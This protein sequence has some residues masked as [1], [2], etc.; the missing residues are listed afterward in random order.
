[1]NTLQGTPTLLRLSLRLD[2]VRLPIWLLALTVCAAGSASSF[3][4]LYPADADRA[5]LLTAANGNPT[6]AAIYGP[7]HA[8][9][10]G[11]LTTWRLLTFYGVLTG[12]MSVLLVI[13]HTRADEEAGRLEL[14]RATVVGRSAR[15]A[16]TLTEALLAVAALAV[17]IGLTMPGPAGSAFALG[18]AV[19]GTGLAAAA[20]AALAAQLTESPR[21]A[22]G[23]A[24][25][26]LG[27]EFAV[28]AVA[29]AAGI[30]WLGWLSPIGWAE[31]MRP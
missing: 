11:A 24:A 27:A 25:A 4:R 19:A 8:A 16:A 29:D 17:L 13:R 12:L 3:A 18:C 14:L 1:M 2:R 20:V 23:I 9:S 7:A 5:K 30:G 10:V 6:F 22:T 28:R 26:F 15:L 31:R 21:A